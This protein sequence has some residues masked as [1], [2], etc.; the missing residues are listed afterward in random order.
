MRPMWAW[1]GVARTAGRNSH[2]WRDTLQINVHVCAACGVHG[3]GER[4]RGAVQAALLAAAA[5]AAA[6]GRLHAAGV[7]R[8]AGRCAGVRTGLVQGEMFLCLH[9]ACP[10]DCLF[11]GDHLKYE[12]LGKIH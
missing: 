7:P 10:D 11:M 1:G 12:M 6:G 8:R 4:H 2:K 9:A 3:A 5:R